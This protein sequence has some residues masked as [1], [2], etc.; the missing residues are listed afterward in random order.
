MEICLICRRRGRLTS[1]LVFLLAGLPEPADSI[2]NV[3]FIGVVQVAPQY[4]VMWDKEVRNLASQCIGKPV[5]GAAGVTF[6]VFNATYGGE[7]H[8]R[9]ASFR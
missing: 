5:E 2:S 1:L 8:R 9:V 3:F 7:V 4:Q 6:V